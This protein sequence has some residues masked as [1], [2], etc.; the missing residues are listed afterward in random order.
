MNNSTS[1]NLLTLQ[2]KHISALKIQAMRRYEISV[3]FFQTTRCHISE[4]SILG[5]HRRENLE[6][7][8][9]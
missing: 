2:W 9:N 7:H 4:D 1:R 3:N 6:L 8:F 5:S